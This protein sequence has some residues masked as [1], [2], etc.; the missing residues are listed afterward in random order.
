MGRHALGGLATVG[1]GK[2]SLAVA[3]PGASLTAYRSHDGLVAVLHGEQS[4]W[5]RCPTTTFADRRVVPL[6]TRVAL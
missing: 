3:F 5:T 4:A 2:Q 6:R 1:R